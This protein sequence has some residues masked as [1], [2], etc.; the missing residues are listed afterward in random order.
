MKHKIIIDHRMPTAGS[1]RYICIYYRYN[2]CV[3]DVKAAVRSMVSLEKTCLH[4]VSAT[5][6]RQTATPGL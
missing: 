3:C 5:D 1:A 6:S 2:V 4:P